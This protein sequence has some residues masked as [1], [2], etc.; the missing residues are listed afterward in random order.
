MK[1]E[2]DARL[3]PMVLLA[4]GLM[5]ELN[6]AVAPMLAYPEMLQEMV[7]DPDQLEMIGDIAAGAQAS[8][9]LLK[10]LQT[11]LRCGSDLEVEEVDAREVLD[12][13]MDSSP[14]RSLLEERS[15]IQLNRRRTDQPLPIRASRTHLQQAIFLLLRHELIRM[16]GDSL[17]DVTCGRCS[18]KYAP[19]DPAMVSGEY[20]TIRF[21]HAAVSNEA[22]ASRTAQLER[23]FAHGILRDLGGSI[24]VEH[25]AS[26]T[27]TTLYLPLRKISTDSGF[28]EVKDDRDEERKRI[29]VVDDL[30]SQRRLTS[31]LLEDLGYEVLTASSGEE[32]LEC[33]ESTSVDL[34]LLDMQMDG[35]FDGYETFQRSL[36]LRPNLRCIVVSAF[37]DSERAKMTLNLGAVGP[38]AKPYRIDDLDRVVR[39]ALAGR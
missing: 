26:G 35:S 19:W 9:H 2:T 7:T 22:P 25:E 5:H 23:S 17:C 36:N 28:F 6:N 34:M 18:L 15:G 38:L 24:R 12:S 10:D 16:E 30:K 4:R 39:D 33:L 3:E 37:T 32:A 31:L 27:S 29:L 13:V 20:A 21:R 1:N 8:T 14:L 11:V